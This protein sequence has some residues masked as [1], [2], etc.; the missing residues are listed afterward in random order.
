M[1]HRVLRKHH[2]HKGKKD[3]WHLYGLQSLVAARFVHVVNDILKGRY[4]LVGNP[5]DHEW[6]DKKKK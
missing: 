4:T 1:S 2:A 5:R 6:Q 3:I